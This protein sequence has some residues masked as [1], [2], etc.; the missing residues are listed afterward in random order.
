M[1]APA[2]ESLEPEEAKAP[3]VKEAASA[4]SNGPAP[5]V[6][7]ARLADSVTAASAGS[8][9]W[10]EVISKLQPAIVALRV[11]CVRSFEEDR[12]ATSVGTGFVVDSEKGLILTNRHIT[13]VGPVRAIAIFDRHEELEV[14]VLYRDPVHDFGFFCYDPSK[15]RLTRSAEVALDPDA[16]RVGAE[17]RVVG[18]DAGE[19]L[20]ILSGTIARVDR[21]VP[22]FSTIYNDE[23]TFY[24]GAGAGTSGGSSGSPVLNKD[25]KAVALNAAGQE[26]TAS[27]FFL[28]LHR[29]KYALELLK[30]GKQVPR[31]ACLASFLFKPFDELIRVGLRRKHEEEVLSSFPD[32][33]GM[34]IVEGVLC[35][36]KVLKPGDVLLQLEGKVC[37]GF[38]QFE[39]IV[40][41]RVGGK[42][43]MLIC[44][45]GTE[46]HLEVDIAD[47][48][49]L[50]PR[51]FVE[52]GLDTLH[53]MGYH[54]ARRAHLPLDGGMYLARTGYVFESLGCGRASLITHVNG[55]PTPTA[56]AFVKALQDI[57]DRQYFPV[58]WY[59]LADFMRD[60]NV[61]TGFA[62]MSRSWSPLRLWQCV[63]ES[64]R[65]HW[66]ATNLP[67]VSKE[68]EPMTPPRVMGLAGV[69]PLVQQLQNSLVNVRFRTDRRFCT[70]APHQGSADGAG[71]LV[72]AE[73]GL[74]L[75]DRH[76]APQSLGDVEVSLA[77]SVTLDGEVI[78][79]HPLHNVAVVR[80]DP[81]AL[82]ALKKA[83]VPLKAAQLARGAHGMPRVGEA[84][85]FVGFDNQ[86][87][88][89]SARVN[90][91]AVYLPSGRDEFPLW[92]VPRFRE[93]NL[94][95]VV[96][97]DTPEDTRGGVLCDSSGTVRALFAAFDWQGASR[98]ETTT[99]AFGIAA[100]IFVPLIEEIRRAPERPLQIASLDLEVNA[101][102]V[103]TLARG[104]KGALPESW[105]H[106]VGQSRGRQ[107][108][109]VARAIRV[110]RIMPT[111][112]V[113]GLLQPGDVILSVNDAVVACGLDIEIAL[114]N[115]MGRGHHLMKK[116]AAGR[117][118]MAVRGKP[119]AASAKKRPAA[120]ME[121][122]A[123]EE[124]KADSKSEVTVSVFRDGQIL[125]LQ[126][127]PSLLGSQDDSRLI[128]WAGL[129][130]RATPRCILERCGSSVARVAG[131]V[132]VQNILG[133][134][135]ADARELNGHCFLVDLEGIPI[136][137]LAD[138][139]PALQKSS[140][141]VERGW[142]RLRF[143]DLYGQEHVKA[144]QGDPL[145]F[146]T[147]DL[148]RGDHG[149]WVCHCPSC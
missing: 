14:E 58:S 144:L 44:R 60:R 49:S 63:F 109:V 41:S 35:E 79:I 78:F 114:E 12:A 131:G 26:G 15:L 108:Q 121:E 110:Q 7:R 119:A 142:A 122:A 149:R 96:L 91:A 54:T 67:E 81:K 143:V 134:S 69:D 75:T 18:N 23:N 137:V 21:N 46:L 45:A 37:I 95:L 125:D 102:D 83:K 132:F 133:G 87:N 48:H 124:Q 147:M 136:Q 90:V 47:L 98:E 52:L 59:E 30:E 139:L 82:A 5:P 34:L 113:D 100:N 94:E 8:G 6:K 25:G 66:E 39:E 88:I 140:A 80:C 85:I 36:Q 93:R 19:K 56:D 107:G 92:D 33:T 148:Q 86:G 29:V 1:S 50:I 118:P 64:G 55:S 106:A 99:E 32:A 127:K 104:A 72:D 70:E 43:E 31:G 53:Q 2:L 73:L 101:I 57:P 135:P 76:A 24:A 105:L 103:A 17:I 51:S 74:V 84:M 13:G 129:V 145:F 111:G 10:A 138:V 16:L 22:E 62:K 40:D 97:A 130:L 146:P 141:A 20:Q 42:V 11:T 116:P 3:A 27:A 38:V 128:L 112:A 120:E 28:P 77:G 9:E 71:I 61:K 126:V 65:E 89:F 123:D 117:K 4:A 115:W 68:Q